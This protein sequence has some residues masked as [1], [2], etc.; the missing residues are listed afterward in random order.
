MSRGVAVPS[1]KELERSETTKKPPKAKKPKPLCKYGPRD[2]DGLCPKKPPKTPSQ[3]G[4]PGAGTSTGS[5]S[6]KSP[7]PL[8]LEKLGVKIITSTAT[9][10]GKQAARQIIPKIAPSKKER[11]AIIRQTVTAGKAGL[12]KI[13]G[14]VT[15]LAG[16]AVAGAGLT[17]AAVAA[18]GLAAGYFGTTYILERLA[19]KKLKN[20]PEYRKYEAAL[21]YAAARRD[22]A[23]RL[24]RELTDA[25]LKYLAAKFKQELLTIGG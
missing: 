6:S 14:G 10:A 15:T 5:R 22:M 13:A 24:G 2:S 1:V 9:A 23:A 18:A 3:S 20:T 4:A 21:A 8:D 12:S 11:A 7:P 19:E 17:A 25:E 16:T